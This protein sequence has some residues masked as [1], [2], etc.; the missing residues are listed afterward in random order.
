MLHFTFRNKRRVSAWSS[1]MNGELACELT[2]CSSPYQVIIEG[3]IGTSHKGDIAIDDISFTSECQP[4]V[5]K[6]F[7]HLSLQLMH[8]G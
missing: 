1:Q 7:S 3:V 8:Y 4:Q 2:T 5:G 6:S